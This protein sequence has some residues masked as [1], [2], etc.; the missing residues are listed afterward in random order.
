MIFGLACGLGFGFLF[1]VITTADFLKKE[2][3][4]DDNKD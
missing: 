3:H 2:C 4:C 1:G